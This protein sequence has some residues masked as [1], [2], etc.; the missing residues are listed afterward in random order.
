MKS[1]RSHDVFNIDPNTMNT[2]SY[3]SSVGLLWLFYGYF[4]IKLTNH[5]LV[6]YPTTQHTEMTEFSRA[7]ASVTLIE[8][9]ENVD[10]SLMPI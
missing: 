10:N 8:E 6:K 1:Y 5:R 4:R 7:K 3:L 2:A 9:L